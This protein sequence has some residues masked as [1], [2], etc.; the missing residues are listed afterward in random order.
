MT[1]HAIHI[2]WVAACWWVVAAYLFLPFLWRHYGHQKKLDGKPMVTNTAIGLPGDPINVGIVGAQDDLVAAMLTA[3]WHAA[4]PVTLS[5]SMHIIG[6]VV[7]HRAYPTAP[8]SPLF[9]DGRVQDLAFEFPVGESAKQR[10]HVRFWKVLVEGDEGRPVWLGAA[11]FDRAVGFSHYTAQVTHHIAAD[12]DAA[13]N[14]VLQTLIKARKAVARYQVT[15][16]GPTLN[17]RNGGGDRYFTDGEIAF[18]RVAPAQEL[19]DGPVQVLPDP[20][21]V[22]LKNRLVRAITSLQAKPSA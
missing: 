20:P 19:H 21:F 14:F 13:R 18:A 10:Q 5:S 3:G 8:V 2:L 4:D 15:G 11:T 1:D 22:T 17:G 6:S 12:V 16:I 9:Y 7:L